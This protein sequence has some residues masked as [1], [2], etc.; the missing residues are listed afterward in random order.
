MLYAILISVYLAAIF[1]SA[2][3]LDSGEGTPKVSHGIKKS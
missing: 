1:I 2:W 3:V